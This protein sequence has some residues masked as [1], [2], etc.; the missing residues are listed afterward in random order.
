MMEGFLQFLGGVLLFAF[1]CFL[2]VILTI[3]F[4]DWREKVSCQSKINNDEYKC[5]SHW[6]AVKKDAA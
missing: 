3:G 4:I 6:H 2:F 5:T 1:G